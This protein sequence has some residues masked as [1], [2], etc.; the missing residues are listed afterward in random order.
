MPLDN[1]LWGDVKAHVYTDKPA[2]ID[3]LEDSIE[4]FICEIPVE[5]L[6]RVCQNWIKE[7]QSR[8]CMSNTVK[9]A[10]KVMFFLLH[11]LLTEIVMLY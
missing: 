2:S 4:A 7:A 11:E 5:M 9:L 1:L 8:L 3:V 6:E 10:P